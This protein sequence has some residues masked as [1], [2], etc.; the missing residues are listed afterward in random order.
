MTSSPRPALA[1]AD[2]S[3][4]AAAFRD[5]HGPRLHGF[6]L[7]VSLGEPEAADRA[8]GEALAAGGQQASALRHP[9]RAAAWLRARALRALH[10]GVS[11][12]TAIPAPARRATLAPFGVDGVVYDGL[13]RLSMEGRAAL[14]A[15]AIERFEPIDTETI[16][17]ASP[18]A[19]RRVIS[20]ARTRYLEAV[21]GQAS[22]HPG[23]VKTEGDLAKRIRE[24]AARAMSAGWKSR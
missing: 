10:Q 2:D 5:L 13:A 12:G 21:E 8:A 24:V 15:S 11:R 16:L 6:A 19:A 23:T 14:V 20:Q 3:K 4:L 9:E 1:Q 18:A 7:L 22:T 17:G